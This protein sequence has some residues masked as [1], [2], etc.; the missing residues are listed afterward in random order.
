[1]I[2]ITVELLSAISPDR[3]R[4]LGIAEIANDGIESVQTQ[5][6]LG[7]YKVRLSKAGDKVRETWKTALVQHFDRKRRGGW[8]LLFL[9]LFAAVGSRNPVPRSP[10]AATLRELADKTDVPT[11]ES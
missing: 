9:A 10:A 8:D 11:K 7:T 4:T 2:K 3:N 1:M 6:R 5:G